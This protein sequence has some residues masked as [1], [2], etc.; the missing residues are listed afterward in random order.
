MNRFERI[1]LLKFPR[2]YYE[3]KIAISMKDRGQENKRFSINEESLNLNSDIIR[4]AMPSM[5][6]ASLRVE[7]KWLDKLAGW[8]WG[9]RV[10]INSEILKDGEIQ[11]SI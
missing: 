2:K 4:F 5:C 7:K 9:Q 6:A 11:K 10:K 8:N 3:R 1:Y